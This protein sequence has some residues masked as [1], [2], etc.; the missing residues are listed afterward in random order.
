MPEGRQAELGEL[1]AAM[2]RL[3]AA[4]LR[5]LHEEAKDL[6][7]SERNRLESL[8]RS[9]RRRGELMLGGWRAMLRRLMAEAEEDAQDGRFVEW[10]S[11][12][13]AH[14]QEFDTGLHS[15]WVDPTV[16]LAECVLGVADTVVVTS[17]TLRDRRPDMPDDWQSAEMRTGASHLPWPVRRVSFRSPFDYAR[18][19]RILLVNDLGRED[20]DQLA[21]AFREL[22]LAAGGGALGLFTAISRLR[23]VHGRI[24][25]PL[26]RN[27]IP[28]H[29]QHVDPMDTGSLVD[30]FRQQEDS[31]L[32]G[33]DAV[34][35]GVDVPGRSLRLMVMDRVPWPRPTILERARR[36][37]FG[38]QAW[39]DMMV[40]LKLRQ[41]FGR[42][43]RTQHDRGV[44]VMLDS[45]LASRFLTAFPENAPVLRV[46]LAEAVRETA[47]FLRAD[48]DRPGR[49][50]GDAP[51]IREML[52]QKPASR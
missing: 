44:F 43:V 13:Y 25:G 49:P 6:T 52:R 5:R 45:R 41:A 51:T 7:G 27:G 9:L 22:F 36:Q 23:A 31:C 47:R 46:G 28:L 10:F 24:M 35:D 1:R 19:A 38:G 42:L 34:R 8:A 16:P 40:R 4:L 17:A 48:G 37:A 15:H 12:Q 20:M 33:T 50:A 29:A 3:A 2:G 30:L 32:L 11:I 18:N 21:A 14:G 39:T 26:A